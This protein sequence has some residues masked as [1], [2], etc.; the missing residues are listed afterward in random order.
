MIHKIDWNDLNFENE[1]LGWGSYGDVYEAIWKSK[2]GPQKI[3]I[4]KF[5][6]FIEDSAIEK[7]FGLLSLTNH[8]N[9]VKLLGI[10]KD[11]DSR[12]V[13]VMEYAECGSLHKVLYQY[14]VCYM[15]RIRWMLQCAKGIEYLHEFSPQILH[16][17]L[18]PQNLLI[19]ND[20]STLKIC[21]FGS[22]KELDTKMSNGVGTA[23]YMAPEVSIQNSYTEKCDVYSFGI[24]FW[25]V[26]SKK[27][28]FYHLRN[29]VD[30]HIQKKAIEGDRPLISDIQNIQSDQIIKLIEQCWNGDSKLRP[31]MQE[32]IRDIQFCYSKDEDKHFNDSRSL[33]EK[34]EQE[35]YICSIEPASDSIFPEIR[36]P[37]EIQF[38]RKPQATVKVKWVDI[39][40]NEVIIH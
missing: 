30:F 16:R 27:K 9:I 4:K 29:T 11:G 1:I 10:A 34:Y 25:E 2:D 28:P 18:K 23:R 3:V 38:L 37:H 13:M 39:S 19:F 8:D 6:P 5:R 32:V 24:T 12:T 21:D 26:M 36:L 31:A 15:R 17:D 40:I 33:L 22:A 14:E 35:Y 7:E 20:Y